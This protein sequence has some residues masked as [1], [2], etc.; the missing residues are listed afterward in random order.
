MASTD[1]S[2]FVIGGWT[3]TSN[4]DLI[5]KFHDNIWSFYGN[6]Q[7]RRNSHASIK[8]DDKIMIIGGLT[9]DGS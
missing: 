8:L 3:G 9:D 1:Q 7:K 2:A 4:L 6:L 5:A